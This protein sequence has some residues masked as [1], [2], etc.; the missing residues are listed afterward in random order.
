M[1]TTGRKLVLGSTWR[2]VNSVAVGLV[3]IL[4]MPFVVHSL[5]DRMYGIWTLVATFMGYSSVI[6]LGLSQAIMRY[7]GR[8]LGAEDHAE[9]NRVFNTSLR[10]YLALG[11]VVLIL[12]VVMAALAPLFCRTPE[13]ASLFWKIILLLGLNF[14]LL[15]PAKVYKGALEAHLR[16]DITAGLDLAA[17]A[18]RTACI[19]GALLLGYKAV[20][21]AWATLL[22]GLPSTAAALYYTHKDLP[23]LE[24]H[25]RYWKRSTARTLFSYSLYSFIS[26]LAGLLRS[27]VD[28]VVVAA[29]ISLE[30]VTHY[31]IGSRLAQYSDEIMTALLGMFPSVFSRQEGARDYDGIRRVF[32]LATKISLVLSSFLSFGLIAWG[33]SFIARWVGPRYVDAYAV[34]VV[35]TLSFYVVLAQ[36][37]STALLYGT[38]KHKFLAWLSSAESL[39]NLA[40]SLVLVRKYGTL[41]VAI[42]TLVPM[43]LGRIVVLPVYVCR[44]SGIGYL[45]YACAMSKTV[46]LILLALAL[47]SFITMKY[48]CPSYAMLTAIALPSGIFYFLPIWL[49]GFSAAEA[50]TMKA[51]VWPAWARHRAQAASTTAE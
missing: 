26:H 31:S 14:A 15:L 24:L 46:G 17:L 2:I 10:I 1:S 38:S 4:M 47:P 45:N 41:G 21:L 39:V 23:F 5:G 30:A 22:C 40:L 36:L 16:Y 28:N 49:F 19:I 35:L 37:P 50:Q 7:L 33:K 29:Y 42:G 25:S 11:G 34:L 13:D 32:F 12:T 43:V 6:E 48:A 8:S 9:C 51:S 44:V 3:S 18:L 20:A 27:R